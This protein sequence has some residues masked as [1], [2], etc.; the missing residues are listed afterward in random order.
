MI[1]QCA[2]RTLVGGRKGERVHP[3]GLAGVQ[4]QPQRS[5]LLLLHQITPL[6][7]R[8]VQ[9]RPRLALTTVSTNPI[10]V[11]GTRSGALAMSFGVPNVALRGCSDKKGLCPGPTFETWTAICTYP[12]RLAASCSAGTRAS[13]K[14]ALQH[15]VVRLKTSSPLVSE[16]K[17]IPRSENSAYSWRHIRRALQDIGYKDGNGNLAYIPVTGIRPGREFQ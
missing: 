17:K 14:P 9:A 2:T 15:D 4:H 10:F 7:V 16:A 11:A 13:A 12:T 6:V 1:V 5:L 3:N 8:P